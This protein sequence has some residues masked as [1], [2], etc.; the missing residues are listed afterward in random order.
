MKALLR[1][2]AP[3]GLRRAVGR[4]KRRLEARR[5]ARQSVEQ[6]FAEIY[7]EGKWATAGHAGA[8]FDSGSGSAT[9]SIVAPYVDAMTKEL[10]SWPAKPQVVDLGCGDFAVGRRL[11]T[12]C[13]RYVAVDVVPA[14][15]NHLRATVKD[16]RVE[17]AC[18]D[19][20]SA[21]DLPDGD[22]CMVRQVL[23]HLS[24]AEIA[25]VIA[26]L[27]KYRQVYITEH[28]P[29]DS[30][31]V[32]PNRDKVHGAD[33]RLY[34]NSGVYLDQPPFSIPREN[35]SMIL[36]TRCRDFGDLYDGGFIRTYRFTPR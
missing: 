33:I 32:V 34:D 2:V 25:A 28:Y 14:L 17:F 16:P 1:A 12:H 23:Q 4:L 36:E 8:R 6:V 30:R 22:I 11:V 31:A 26:K 5:N 7:R 24:N 15:V 13:E 10:R 27:G 35:L 19:I 20:T 29:A 9:E 3:R 21:A 18:L